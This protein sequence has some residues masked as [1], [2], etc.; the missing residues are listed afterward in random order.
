M[1]ARDLLRLYCV[2][3]QSSKHSSHREAPLRNYLDL[4]VECARTG[5][6]QKN[7][8]GIDTFMIPG[9]KLSFDLARGFPIVTTKKI[10]FRSICAELAGFIRGADS[11]KEFR[12]LGTTIWDANAN[13]PRANGGKWI[14]NPNRQGLDHLGRI[15]GQQ[16]RRWRYYDKSAFLAR[17]IDQLAIA[18]RLLKE[19]PTSRR[20]I[21]TAWQPAELDEMA[22][23][24]CHL[25]FQLLVTQSDQRLHMT[26]YQR[27]CDMFLGVTFNIS[28]YALLLSLIAQATGYT[29]GTLTMFLADV[30][31]YENHLN[32][33]DEQAQR[34]PLPLPQLR[35]P[36]LEDTPPLAYLN[37]VDPEAI[38]LVGYRSHPPIK[39][40]MAV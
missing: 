39:G 8:T 3:G 12:L 23:P 9:A 21:V 1:A 37:Q 28:S 17:H 31:V 33:V 10:A 25:L 36:P 7:R 20:I 6:R 18:L 35:L 19:D 4:L 13:D 11:A 22:L 2:S 34:N 30:H 27:S 24:P 29:P 38:S 15:Y 32:Q 26:M 16:W 14:N 40:E 5:V